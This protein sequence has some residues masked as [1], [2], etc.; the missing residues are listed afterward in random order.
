[1]GP[2][3]ICIGAQRAGTTWLHNEL[4]KREDVWLPPVKEVHYFDRK[5]P[6]KVDGGKLPTRGK[7]GLIKRRLERI[8]GKKIFDLI[9]IVA[10]EDYRWSLKYY[11]GDRN[12]SWY[13][14]L[15]N[16]HQTKLKGDITP[17]YALLDKSAV[18]SIYSLL[19]EVKIIFI[20]RDPVERA[21]SQ[22]IKELTK[23]KKSTVESLPDEEL[24][25]HFKSK[26]SMVRGDYLRTIRIWSD[27]YGEDNIKIV[28]FDD[29]KRFPQDTISDIE[30][31]LLLPE[32]NSKNQGEVNKNAGDY[33]G[34]R[35]SSMMF[36]SKLYMANL[37]VM[38]K[39]LGG[40]CLAWLEKAK[41]VKR[42]KH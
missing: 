4:N 1:M 33:S 39:E 23:F 38:S 20:I 40:H 31:F 5:Y 36:L 30:D 24:E 13:L 12:D 7:L 28:Y 14:S 19:P 6:L 29:I 37:E 35:P 34:I 26:N 25:A 8:K 17:A 15:F 41:D 32:G 16:K 3:F 21:W 10:K 22:A 2:D 11:F 9:K 27:I 18:G 42:G